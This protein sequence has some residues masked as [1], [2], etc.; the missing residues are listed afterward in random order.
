MSSSFW[1]DVVVQGIAGQIANKYGS[2]NVLTICIFITGLLM[3][4]TPWFADLVILN[5]FVAVNIKS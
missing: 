4:S 1:G 3:M 5:C 2:K